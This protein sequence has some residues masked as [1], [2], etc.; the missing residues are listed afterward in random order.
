MHSKSIT[1]LFQFSI[2]PENTQTIQKSMCPQSPMQILFWALVYFLKKYWEQTHHLNFLRWAVLCC[3]QLLQL[4]LTVCS[5]RQSPTRLLCPWD[6]PDENPGVG[7]RALVQG[8]FPIQRLNPCLLSL[9]TWRV[10]SLLLSQKGSLQRCI[11]KGDFNSLINGT[12]QPH[13]GGLGFT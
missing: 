6:S 5:H 12:H 4:Y 2:N 1:I 8:I 9:L 7:C 3:A 11:A 13:L 10:N